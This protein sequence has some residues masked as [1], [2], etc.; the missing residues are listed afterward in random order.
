[1][2]PMAHFHMVIWVHGR[3]LVYAHVKGQQCSKCGL[4][5]ELFFVLTFLIE[6]NIRV[7]RFYLKRII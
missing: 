5:Y 7:E 1:M 6:H 3:R 2:G 4:L